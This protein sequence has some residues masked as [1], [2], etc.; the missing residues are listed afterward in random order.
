MKAT[1][2]IVVPV[3]NEQFRLDFSYFSRLGDLTSVQFVFVDD[4]SSDDTASGIRGFIQGKLNFSLIQL[5]ENVGKANAIRVGW[6]H[7]NKV[8]DFTFLGFLDAD[9]A[10][11][12]TDVA[13]LVALCASENENGTIHNR[14]PHTHSIDAYWSS[15]INLSGRMIDRSP[16]RY[17]MGRIFASIIKIFIRG[18]PWDTQSGFKLFRNDI[19]FKRSLQLP[20]SCKWLFDIELLL[21]LRNLEDP[22][23][24]VW[25]EPVSKWHDVPG[26]KVTS[27]QYLTIMSDLFKLIGARKLREVKNDKS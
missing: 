19:K 7:L 24:V 22:N 2:G 18:L 11:D 3:Y 5:S 20:F 14:P 8:A 9:G 10:F 16:H 4:G 1:V 6:L 15:R 27:S 13:Y 23:Y 17:L 21:R 25:E 12:Y 26:S